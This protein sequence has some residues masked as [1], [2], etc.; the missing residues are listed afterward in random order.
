MGEIMDTTKEDVVGRLEGKTLKS[1]RLEVSN[2]MRVVIE[3]FDEE[4][5]KDRFNRITDED[6]DFPYKQAEDYDGWEIE[7]ISEI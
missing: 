1:F 7:D 3:A 6:Y 2:K 4:D 5:A